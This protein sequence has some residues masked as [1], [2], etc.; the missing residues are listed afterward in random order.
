MHAQVAGKVLAALG[1]DVVDLHVPEL[2]D[3][4]DLKTLSFAC[5]EAWLAEAMLQLLRLY[6]VDEADGV[7]EEAPVAG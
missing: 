7:G 4:V 5:G 2:F 1:L 3:P 6:R